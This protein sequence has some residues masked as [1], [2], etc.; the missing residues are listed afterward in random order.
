MVLSDGS[1]IVCGDFNVE[2]W[3]ISTTPT[4]ASTGYNTATLECVGTF[5]GHLAGEK[6]ANTLITATPDNSMKQWNIRTGE[7]LKT[8]EL[9][10][11]A[12]ILIMTRDKSKVLCGLNDGSFELRR[13]T[14][15]SLISTFILYNSYAVCCCELEDGSFVSGE[16]T[17]MKR[18]NEEGR[19]LQT[20]SGHSE[21]VLRVIELKRGIILSASIDKTMKMWKVSSGDCF[22]TLNQD[23]NPVHQLLKLS[24]DKFLSCDETGRMQVWNDGG[25]CV[26]TIQIE[27]G[28]MAMTRFG[29]EIITMSYFQC[30]VSV[31]RIR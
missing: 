5:T 23:V 17:V 18:W 8:I 16:S 10:S 6:D 15:L 29:D 13:S 3:I 27:K 31:R 19:V 20:F 24:K 2:R 28:I 26:E 22:L 12:C 21:L 25:D 4:S 30:T 14:D 7:C 1:F 11:L 9:S